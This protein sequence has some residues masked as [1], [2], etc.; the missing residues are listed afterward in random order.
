M[1]CV[2]VCT[3]MCVGFVWGGSDEPPTC[4]PMGKG[5]ASSSD[6]DDASAAA[7]ASCSPSTSIHAAC[8]CACCARTVMFWNGR[9]PGGESLVSVETGGAC[10]ALAGRC[11]S[12]RSLCLSDMNKKEER[13]SCNL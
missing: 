1:G 9:P 3:Y 4:Q 11:S 10:C 2:G 12:C 5:S 8:C 13:L 6:E 7:A